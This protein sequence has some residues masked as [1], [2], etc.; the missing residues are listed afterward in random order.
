MKVHNF[1]SY[2]ANRQIVVKT[3]SLAEMRDVIKRSASR[4]MPYFDIYISRES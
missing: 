2:P 3:M 1:F 4:N